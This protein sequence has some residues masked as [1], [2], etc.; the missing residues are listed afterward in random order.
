MKAVK[1]LPLVFCCL[2]AIA[3]IAS[4]VAVVMGS[5]AEQATQKLREENRGEEADYKIVSTFYETNR[6][7]L[8][9][10]H[11]QEEMIISLP[12]QITEKKKE[13]F[14]TAKK[15][16][17]AILA[18]KSDLKIAYLTF[19]DGPYDLTDQYLDV[20]EHCD[21]RATF[22][23]LGKPKH[24]DKYQLYQQKGHTLANHTYSHQIKNGIY[25]SSGAFLADV[26]K[27]QDYIYNL[28]GE[29]TDIVRFPGGSPT[30][31]SIKGEIIE[32]LHGSGYGYVDW[33][34]AT[35]D[36]MSGPLTSEQA[37]QNLMETIKG[38]QIA[39]VLMHDYSTATLEALP[40]CIESLREQGYIFLPLFRES[41]MIK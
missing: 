31:G 6:T 16:E 3:F 8:E 14:E 20:L 21:I 7:E 18:G 22:F 17:D 10:L 39:V 27:L 23:L 13:Y 35:M 9:Q 12:E 5:S 38:D 4:A 36:G 29:T 32:K 28:T 1:H 15:L 41:C 40:R 2:T 37:Y 30:A 33:T 25:R 26:K 34:A 19:D 24:A 11:M